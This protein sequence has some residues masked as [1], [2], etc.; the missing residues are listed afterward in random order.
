MTME[1]CDTI[2]SPQTLIPHAYQLAITE[3]PLKKLSASKKISLSVKG[4]SVFIF[5]LTM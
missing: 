5:S 3:L 2:L 1:K 4:D